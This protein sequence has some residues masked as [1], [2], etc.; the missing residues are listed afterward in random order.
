MR[1]WNDVYNGGWN[2]RTCEE[3]NWLVDKSTCIAREL[4]V[5]CQG[6]HEHAHLIG[7]R[8]S[9]CEVYPDKLCEA[10]LRGLKAQLV[11]DNIL[12]IGEPLQTVCTEAK[13]IIANYENEHDITFVDDVTGLVLDT[14]MVCAARAM[15][16]RVFE[17]H[18]VYTKVPI[19]EAWATTGKVRLV[20]SGSTS[21]RVISKSPTIGQG[22]LHKS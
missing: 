4:E 21:I 16:M 18:E 12:L 20:P 10:I 6:G 17:Y 1:A 22:L 15:K 3:T 14:A 9:K 11:K 5:Q 13:Q 19:E 7:G 8:A 2:A